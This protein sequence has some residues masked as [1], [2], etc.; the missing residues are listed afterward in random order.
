M[1]DRTLHEAALADVAK[2][3]QDAALG[4]GEKS[5]ARLGRKFELLLGQKHTASS[6]RG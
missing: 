6:T 5:R 3:A 1:T 4:G 2:A